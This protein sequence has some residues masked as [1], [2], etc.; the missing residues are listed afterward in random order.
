VGA[1]V[2]IA[3]AAFGVKAIV[4]VHDSDP[5]CPH[6]VCTTAAAFRQNQDAHVA[7]RVAD[8]AVPTGLAV[9]GAG[10]YLLLRPPPLAG[11]RASSTTVRFEP[12]AAPHAASLTVSTSW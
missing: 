12:A 5:S 2:A 8:I 7:A 11:A 1:V 4:D 3:G 9:A 6:D 10:L